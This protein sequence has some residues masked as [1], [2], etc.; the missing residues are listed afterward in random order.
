MLMISDL[1]QIPCMLIRGGTSKGAYFLA[2]DLPS[3]AEALRE[4]LVAVM[5]SPDPRQIDGIG[6]GH[7]LTSK[8]ALIRRATSPDVDLEYTFVQVA[9]EQATINTRQTCGNILVGVGAFALERGLVTVRDPMTPIR[10]LMT[11]TGARAILNMQSPG[12]RARYFGDTRIDGVAG[13]HSPIAVE[14]QDIAGSSC[15]A[16]LP[17]GRTCEEIEGVPCT[18]IDY[19][20][21]VVVMAA[22]ALGCSG[23]EPP[24]ALE[25]DARLRHR[26]ETIR[27]HAGELMSLGDVAGKSIPKITLVSPPCHGGSLHTRT[28]IPHRV[29]E[30]IGVLGAV[31]VAAAAAL[32]G[33][34]IGSLVEG[35]ARSPRAT[36]FTI[37][38]PA[39]YLDVDI[40]RDLGSG[41][42]T[43]TSLIRTARPLFDGA[44]YVDTQLSDR[45]PRRCEP[46]SVSMGP[47]T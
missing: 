2:E 38:H 16:A 4:V 21:P 39:G 45:L 24:A 37:E 7:P 8:V 9:V 26:L 34:V 29:H 47:S 10:V 5:G 28:F 43:R 36:R 13:R 19:G 33:S 22:E 3:D 30:A 31:S 1:T 46:G 12:A 20:M 14:F 18:L 40:E 17:T 6:G 42:I 32:P 15:G 35:P 25:S 44:V 11:N 27:L 23:K 41:E